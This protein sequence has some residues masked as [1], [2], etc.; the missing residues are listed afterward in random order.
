MSEDNEVVLPPF[1]LKSALNVTFTLEDL[2]GLALAT[3]A[4]YGHDIDASTVKST[5][6]KTGLTLVA[7]STFGAP[8][9]T[10]PKKRR[11]S[12]AKAQI[13]QPDEAV[14]STDPTEDPASSNADLADE[15]VQFTPPQTMEAN[16]G[17]KP[18]AEDVINQV[19]SDAGIP[20]KAAFGTSE[21][22]T[23]PAAVVGFD[24]N[25]LGR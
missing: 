8:P 20:T 4:D 7:E 14:G 17:F 15:P 2:V 16:L 11:R 18:T 25:T 12:K 24:L 6:T 10:E 1:V 3:L 13:A 23:A 21:V 22:P 9:K 5:V 19:R